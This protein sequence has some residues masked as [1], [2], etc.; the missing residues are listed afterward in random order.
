MHAST[1]RSL[2]L[3]SI[4][5]VSHV[6]PRMRLHRNIVNHVFYFPLQSA[7]MSGFPAGVRNPDRNPHSGAYARVTTEPDHVKCRL[8]NRGRGT[9]Q[10]HFDRPCF[11]TGGIPACSDRVP[12]R[13]GGNLRN[14]DC[15]TADSLTRTGLSGAH[16]TAHALARTPLFVWTSGLMTRC[17]CC[18]MIRAPSAG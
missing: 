4:V 5:C 2:S 16:A 18:A 14:E 3:L 11:Y 9:G 8:P 17:S 13:P 10:R 12:S 15:T 6:R 7:R 1:N